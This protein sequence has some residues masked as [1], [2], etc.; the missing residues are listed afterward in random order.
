MAQKIGFAQANDAV[1]QLVGELLDQMQRSQTDYTQ[2]F[3]GLGDI[4]ANSKDTHPEL[5]D[6]FLQRERFDRWLH[7]YR[8]QLR[9]TS[10]SDAERRKMMMAV[11][12]KYVLRNYMAQVA[13]ENAEQDQD[14]SELDR[15][16]QFLQAP[17]DEHPEKTHYAEPPPD[18]AGSIQVSC[19]S[20]INTIKTRST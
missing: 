17:F 15:L 8:E 9:T 13:I 1:L 18:W 14:F 20:R 7:D 3:R 4:Q 12:P 6:M 10:E 2:L 5:R 19:S 16:M 11:N